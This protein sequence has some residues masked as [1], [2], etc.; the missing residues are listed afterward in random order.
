MTTVSPSQLNYDHYSEHKY[1]SDIVNSIPHHRQ[2]HHLVANFVHKKLHHKNIEILDLGVGTGITS[3]LLQSLLPSAQLTVVDFSKQMLKNA[4][5]KLGKKNV[6][7]L[8]GDYSKF[9]FD[10]KYDLIISVIGLH[11]QNNAGKKK[12]FKKIYSLLKPDGVF[13]F[14]DLITYRD[15]YRAAY[16]H[17]LHFH[18]LVEHATDKKTLTEWA[19]HHMFLNELAPIEDQ[20]HWLKQVGFKVEIKFLKTNTA[21]LICKK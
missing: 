20:V 11:H 1:D 7:Y 16:N 15:K 13:I 21:L 19:H 9:K 5:N 4:V 2:I 18:H 10:Q 3:K 12:M 6:K 17:S 14:G 8:F